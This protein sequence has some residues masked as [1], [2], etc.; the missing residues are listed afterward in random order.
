V[1]WLF[2][3]GHAADLV[4][5][6]LLL[7]YLWLTLAKGRAAGEVAAILLPAAMMM[8]ALRAALTGAAWPWIALPLAAAFPIHLL[9]LARHRAVTNRAG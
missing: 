6:V 5:A 8:L 4:L 9:D 2:E 7:E 3:S 1:S